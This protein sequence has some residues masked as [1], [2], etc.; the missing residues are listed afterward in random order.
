[1]K[2]V[3]RRF[4]K[5]IIEIFPKQ[6]KILCG[7]E[8]YY[9]KNRKIIKEN[10]NVYLFSKFLLDKGEEISY[11][12]INKIEIKDVFNIITSKTIIHKTYPYNDLFSNKKQKNIILGYFT[13]FKGDRYLEKFLDKYGENYLEKFEKINEKIKKNSNNFKYITSSKFASELIA[14]ANNISINNFIEIGMSRNNIKGIS[15]D[16]LKKVFNINNKI[17]KIILYTPTFRDKN[18]YDF[19]K[20]KFSLKYDNNIFGYENTEE[21]LSEILER[22]NI[23]IIIKLHKF[24]PYYEE[25]ERKI[26]S[27]EIKLPKNCLVFSSELEDKYNIGIYNL[28]DVSDAMIADY[29]SIS[30]DYLLK[31]KPIFYNIFDIDEYREYRGFSYEP[32]EE[33]MA[34][35]LIRNK[36]EF[37]NILEKFGKN[38]KDN[39]KEKRQKVNLLVNGMEK[40]E[41]VNEKI[42]SFIKEFTND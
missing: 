37:L 15:L 17:N 40:Q 11:F 1:M 9:E 29:S 24:F 41:N 19:K 12:N 20:Y 6:N 32:I 26:L 25:K 39:Y 14:K 5:Y 28:F 35:E 23:Y 7:I 31:D 16:E 13:P 2:K 21:E 8:F 34:G 33:L 4:F 30:F 27:G 38:Y 18:V 22:N 42:Y 10:N 36:K 3:L